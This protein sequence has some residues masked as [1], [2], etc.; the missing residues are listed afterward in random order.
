MNR[1]NPKTKNIAGSIN[2]IDTSIWIL[3]STLLFTTLLH[4]RICNA[5]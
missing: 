4:T 3:A 1:E 5:G 2:R